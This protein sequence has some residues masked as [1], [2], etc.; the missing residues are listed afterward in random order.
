MEVYVINTVIIPSQQRWRGIK[1][2]GRSCVCACTGPSRFALDTIAT[3]VFAQSL[4]FSHVSCRWWEEEPY[5]FWVTGS[6]VKVNFGTLCIRACGHDTDYSL[7]PIT[8]KLHIL[9]SWLVVLRIYVALAVFQPYHDLEA[10]DNQSLKFKWR[11]WILN[12]GPLAPQARSL[13]TRPPPLPKTSHVSCGWWEEE[14]Y[15]FG[16]TV[17]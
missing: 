12:P 5:W 16:V 2:G 1:L 11:D 8:F 7:C 13:T 4:P 9:V 10:E 3:T 14:P 15:W 17:S 6:K